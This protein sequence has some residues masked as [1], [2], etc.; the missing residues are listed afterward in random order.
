MADENINA[1]KTFQKISAD[2]EMEN[3]K[4]ANL[5]D[6]IAI[7]DQMLAMGGSSTSPLISVNAPFLGLYQTYM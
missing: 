5:R 1:K 6:Q 3:K 2:L 7:L 4:I